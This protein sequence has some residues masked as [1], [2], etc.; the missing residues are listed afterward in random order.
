MEKMKKNAKMQNAQRETT[1]RPPLRRRC[2]TREPSLLSA[3]VGFTVFDPN[4]DE[5]LV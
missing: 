1:L 4:H 3:I 2:A 5:Q